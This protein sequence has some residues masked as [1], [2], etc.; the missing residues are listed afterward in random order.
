M[1]EVTSSIEQRLASIRADMT[2]T[3][4]ALEYQADLAARMPEYRK[5]LFDKLAPVVAGAAAQMGSTALHLT[6]A[7]ATHFTDAA[8]NAAKKTSSKVAS[9]GLLRILPLGAALIVGVSAGLVWARRR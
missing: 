3:I 6:D 4:D 2:A 5:A 1:G 8:A 9:V 7:A